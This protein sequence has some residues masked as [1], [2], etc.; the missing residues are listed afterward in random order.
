M[1]RVKDS[2]EASMD[3]NMGALLWTKT[4]ELLRKHDL[5]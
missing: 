5:P 1:M 2:S 3:P 4:E